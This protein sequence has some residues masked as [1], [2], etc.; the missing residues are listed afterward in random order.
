MS[1]VKKGNGLTA[2]RPPLAQR[3]KKSI[4][5]KATR[6]IIRSHHTLQKQLSQAVK[7]GDTAKAA[8]VEREIEKHGGI[9]AYQQASINGQSSDRGGDSS[10]VLMKWLGELDIKKQDDPLETRLRLLEIGA[11]STTN[12]CSQSGIF[13]VTHI[14]LNSQDPKIQQQDFMQRPLPIDD[15]ERFD[16]ISLSLVLNYV[17]DTDGR[18]A[19]LRRTRE[20][21]KESETGSLPL[22]FLVLPAACVSNARYMTEKR[23]DAIMTSLGFAKLKHKLSPQLV[24]SLWRLE[25]SSAKPSKKF[26]KV[27]VNP[28]TTR[29]NFSIILR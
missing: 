27:E 23:L 10:K 1:K 7:T 9:K 18:G 29:N 26:L 20:F 25:D 16:A 2:G 15:E 4:T 17:P 3:P 24:Y 12:A 8:A 21:L 19:M 14:D 28:G 13:E 6:T 5:S 11:L 22:L